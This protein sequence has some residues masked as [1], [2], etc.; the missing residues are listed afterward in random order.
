MN[1]T[2]IRI[3]L[4][5][6]LTRLKFYVVYTLC[7]VLNSIDFVAIPTQLYIYIYVYIET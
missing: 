5:I 1:K 4:K 2:I 7:L 6:S 3:S